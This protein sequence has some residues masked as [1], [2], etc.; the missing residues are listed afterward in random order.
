[1][2]GLIINFKNKSKTLASGSKIAGRTRK[3]YNVP[4]KLAKHKQRNKRNTEKKQG[5]SCLKLGCKDNRPNSRLRGEQSRLEMLRCT[6]KVTSIS[7]SEARI[8]IYGKKCYFTITRH[9]LSQG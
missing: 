3:H 4:T 6:N 7:I 5:P 1:M 8:K 2:S 9:S